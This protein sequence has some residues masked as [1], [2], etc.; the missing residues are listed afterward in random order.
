[1]QKV[2]LVVRDKAVLRIIGK[3]LRAGVVM[4]EGVVILAEEGTPQGGPLS[5]RTQKVTFVSSG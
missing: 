3:F 2:G 1:M 4:E 5:P